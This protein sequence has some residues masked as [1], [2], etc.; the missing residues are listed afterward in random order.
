[1]PERLE[2]LYSE[3]YYSGKADYTYKDERKQERF[4]RF[5][6]KARLNRIK[7][8]VPAPADFLDVG[9][10]YGGLALEAASMGYSSQGLD[11]SGHAVNEAKKRGLKAKQGRITDGLFAP[12][13]IDIVTMIEVIEHLEDPQASLA[14]LSRMIRPGGLLVIQTANFEGQQA[15]RGGSNYH[16]YLP[17]H[18][19]YFSKSNL[20]RLLRANGFSKTL[21]FPGVEFGLLPKLLKSRGN[22]QT[23]RDYAKWLRISW[24]HAMSK[25]AAGSFAMTSAMVLYAFRDS[26]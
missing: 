6:W 16:Y 13:S 9:C 3:D 26:E 17:G 5:V 19:F 23:P 12:R 10:A 24:Y 1:M 14:E 21:F 15:K 25:L 22:F 7:E 4:E 18:L 8:F 20:T 11:L 2:D